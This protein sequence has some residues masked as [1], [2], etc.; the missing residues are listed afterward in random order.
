[1]WTR[2]GGLIAKLYPVRLT[3]QG[4]GT[5]LRR[6]GLSFQRPDQRAVEQDAEVVR[7]WREKTGRRS[8]PGRR[9]RAARCS[10]PTRPA[11][12]P[13]RSPSA[14][15]PPRGVPPSCVRAGNRFSVNAIPA[16]SAKGRMRLTVLT[17]AFGADAMGFP[18]RLAGHFDH[19]AHLV[20]DGHSARSREVRAC[21]ADHPY[22]VELHFPPSCSPEPTPDEL[23]N[24]DLTRSLP[25]H[26]R[27]RD[28]ARLATEV[29]RFSHRL[30]R[31]P[32]SVRGHFGGPHVATPT[33]RKPFGFRLVSVGPD[34]GRP[35]I[36]TRP[37]LPGSG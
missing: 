28:R 19:R 3:E 15:G 13:T 21:L 35:G 4:V 12:V 22:C 27:A 32:H 6:W 36:R 9:P 26:G 23:V 2:A 5:Y 34:P 7:V 33:R 16:I 10:S 8:G 11:S 37:A 1:M 31:Q 29:R 14:P 24:A 20:V 18:G 25:M 30:P 17:E